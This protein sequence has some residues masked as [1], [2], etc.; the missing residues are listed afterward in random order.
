MPNIT[1][2]INVVCPE[3]NRS[4]LIS[5]IYKGNKITIDPETCPKCDCQ[6]IN[7]VVDQINVE[8]EDMP[9]YDKEFEKTRQSEYDHRLSDCLFEYIEG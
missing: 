7:D 3:C 5:F 8:I 6:W 9:Q 4:T 1:D 2:E